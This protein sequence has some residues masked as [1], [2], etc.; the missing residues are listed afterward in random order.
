MREIAK[1]KEAPSTA[2]DDSGTPNNLPEQLTSFIGRERELSEAAKALGATRLL[3]MTGA[4][5][6]GKTRLAAQAA[7]EQLDRFPD[8]AWWIEL[9]PLADPDAVGAALGDAVGVK[10]LPGQSSLDAAVA[11]LA[12]ARALVVLDNC[13]HLLE[14][15]AT[16]AEALLHG[17]PRVTV[18]ATSRA[19]LGVAGE[20]D[21]R[22]PSL[23]LPSQ[24]LQTEPVEALAESDAVRLFVERA[25]KVR[26]NF[27]VDT[28]NAAAI[29]QIC[30]DLDG[31]PLAI[32]LAAAR[33][34]VLGVERI[35]AGLGDRFQ[36]LT[37]G[38]RSAMPRQ[39]TLARL[40]RL[41]PRSAR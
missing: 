29:A 13:E 25:R 1:A 35:A 14:A 41:E 21:W 26:P 32:E 7:A 34:R 10:P 39:K 31:I 6:C 17:C 36:L 20:A 9:A 8:G 33:V 18:M 4:G 28:A 22:V 12:E 16:A 38:A 15:C 24:R 11:H 23:S 37:G 27:S 2:P 5:G 40:G 19:P 30:N 3:T